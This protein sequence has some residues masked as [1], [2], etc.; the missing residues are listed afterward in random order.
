MLFTSRIVLKTSSLL[1]ELNL[2]EYN[3]LFF[4]NLI[5][6]NLLLNFVYLFITNKVINKIIE[7]AIRISK[8]PGLKIN[9]VN[10]KIM[11]K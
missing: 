10:R 8:Y 2:Q 5:T 7:V 3:N 11:K 6:R 4:L 9:A 1:F